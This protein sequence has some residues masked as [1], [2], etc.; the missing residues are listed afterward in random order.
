MTST[1]DFLRCTYKGD[2][3]VSSVVWTG[4]DGTI[5]ES[6]V[7]CFF[8]SYVLLVTKCL[9]LSIHGNQTRPNTLVVDQTWPK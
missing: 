7:G 3:D 8:Q 4:P 5:D 1:T 6:E 2:N 9:N